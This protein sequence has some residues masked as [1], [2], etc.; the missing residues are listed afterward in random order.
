MIKYSK[1]K[2]FTLSL[3]YC[4]IEEKKIQQVYFHL[5]TALSTQIKS[6]MPDT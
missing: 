4:F 6:H 5:Q 1:S 2:H 3:S